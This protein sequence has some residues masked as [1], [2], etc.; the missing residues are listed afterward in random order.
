[1]PD[2]PAPPDPTHLPGPSPSRRG[3]LKVAGAI[4]A[5]AAA[6]TVGCNPSSSGGRGEAGE[7]RPSRNAGF[8]RETLAALG[9]AVL[10]ESLGAAGRAAAVTAFVAWVNGYD[11]VAEEMHGYGYS[12]IRYLPPDPAPAWQAQLEGLDL[13][14]QKKRRKPFAQLDIAARRELVTPALDAV[15]GERLP[16]PLGAS[17]VAVALMAHWAASPA[18]W[19]LALGA[20][21]GTGTCRTLDG[22]GAKP[23]PIAGVTA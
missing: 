18:A 8:D 14:A 1:M 22:V 20:Q 13:L 12:D 21:V 11:P 5:G 6:T 10:P 17:H 2:Q 16:D 3:F 15:P 23:L 19:D 4:A 7:R 9:E